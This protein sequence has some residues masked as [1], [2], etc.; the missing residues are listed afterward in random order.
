MR[1]CR[2]KISYDGTTVRVPI[3]LP[4]TT[5]FPREH[6]TA[7]PTR[8]CL[9]S[10][11]SPYQCQQPSFHTFLLLLPSLRLSCAPPSC[12]PR[13]KNLSQ[14]P[15]PRNLR[16]L[17]RNYLP[18]C[19]PQAFLVHTLSQHLCFLEPWSGSCSSRGSVEFSYA[20]ALTLAYG[21]SPA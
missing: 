11:G 2:V 12:P 15:L 6:I 17:C 9:T 21:A 13:Y 3:S 20:I 8:E 4:T 7:P 14:L 16:S 18:T 10:R 5:Q 1:S 19:Q